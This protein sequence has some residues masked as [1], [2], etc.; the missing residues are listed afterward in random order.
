LTAL[1]S[2]RDALLVHRNQSLVGDGYAMRVLTL[3][4]QPSYAAKTGLTARGWGKSGRPH[5]LR[6]H[7][8]VAWG[9]GDR[10]QREQDGK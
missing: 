1:G 6:R 9:V 7:K 2:K 4:R 3:C 5:R 10:K 8:K